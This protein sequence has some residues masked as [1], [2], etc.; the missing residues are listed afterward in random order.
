M[1]NAFVRHDVFED[2]PPLC[3][4]TNAVITEVFS[5]PEMVMAK[6][7]LNIYHG[8]LQVSNSWHMQNTCV[9]TWSEYLA[10]HS[11]GI[12]TIFGLVELPGR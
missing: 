3:A 7:V 8:K 4:R 11:D 9:Y 1:Q 10:C 12:F 6:L 2:I 5:N